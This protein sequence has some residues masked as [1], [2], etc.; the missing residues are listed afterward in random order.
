MLLT[1]PALTLTLTLTDN[2]MGDRTVG[3]LR[4]IEFVV[5][6]GNYRVSDSFTFK[7][8]VLKLVDVL[9]V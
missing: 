2:V 4:L 1:W 3:Y 7:R 6:V 5:I 8:I 9:N